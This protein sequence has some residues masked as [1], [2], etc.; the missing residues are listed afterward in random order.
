[1]KFLCYHNNILIIIVEAFFLVDW[2]GE[3][4]HSVVPSKDIDECAD[5]GEQVKVRVG[6]KHYDAI[7][8]GRGNLSTSPFQEED[9]YYIDHNYM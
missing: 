3:D 6:P 1:M 7:V 4:T 9:V 2:V 5:V 8:L